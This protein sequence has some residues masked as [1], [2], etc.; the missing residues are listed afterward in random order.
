MKTARS[1]KSFLNITGLL[2]EWVRESQSGASLHIRGKV[3]K[4]LEL[5]RAFHAAIY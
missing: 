4:Y 3:E 1:P 5:P 2:R